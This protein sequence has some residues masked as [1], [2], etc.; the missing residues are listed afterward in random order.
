MCDIEL[1]FVTIFIIIS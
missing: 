1:T